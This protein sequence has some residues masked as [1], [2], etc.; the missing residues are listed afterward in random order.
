MKV[1]TG[2]ADNT[3]KSNPLHTSLGL[4]DR[5]VR[6]IRD[7][8][9]NA[10]LEMTPLAIKEMVRQYNNAPHSSLS[11]WIGFDVSP[12][13][14]QRDKNKEEYIVMKINKA[15]LN[16][17]MMHSFDLPIGSTVK[18]YNEKDT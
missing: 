9:F 14:V 6:T 16:T 17:R 11:K 15:N 8:I 3:V 1:E 4:I 10:G 7:M 12:L 5:M 18:V 2:T 13:T